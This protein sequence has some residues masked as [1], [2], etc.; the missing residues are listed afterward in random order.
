MSTWTAQTTVR[1]RPEDVFCTLVDPDA[2]QRWSP[3]DFEIEA[4]DGGRLA[5]GGQARV[6]GRLAGMAVGFDVDVAH[7]DGERLSL[8]AVGPIGLDVDYRLTALD[9]GSEICASVSVRRGSGISG[10]VL[11]GATDALLAGGALQA[12]IARI[13][14]QAEA[15]L[16]AGPYALAA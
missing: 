14:R 8:S 6:V 13:A 10:R 12:A 5:A 2:I 11:A 16:E 15:P 9:E 3:V 1:S 7:A 4:L